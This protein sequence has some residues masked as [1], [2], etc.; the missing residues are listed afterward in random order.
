MCLAT[1]RSWPSTQRDLDLLRLP[2]G[3]L[4]LAGTFLQDPLCY[5]YGRAV[6]TV[7]MPALQCSAY[8][9]CRRKAQYRYSFSDS[10]L[11]SFSGERLLIA[12]SQASSPMR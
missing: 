11:L 10:I 1:A 4:K 12:K 5:A 9:S 2:F 6:V 8:A 7:L 3:D